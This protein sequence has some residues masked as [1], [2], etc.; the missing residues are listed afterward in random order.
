[1]AIGEIHWY[2]TPTANGVLLIPSQGKIFDLDSLLYQD[3]RKELSESLNELHQ[4]QHNTLMV[5]VRPCP[6]EPGCIVH[7][8]L[9]ITELDN[10]VS[11]ETHGP[12]IMTVMGSTG[13]YVGIHGDKYLKV[14]TERLL[15]NDLHQIDIPP[16]TEYL[17]PVTDMKEP[18]TRHTRHEELTKSNQIISRLIKETP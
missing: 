13:Y 2:N 5:H 12:I 16:E 18:W 6:P 1:M 15:P 14:Y 17:S 4:N 9:K 7:P 3:R 11:I 8:N 10:E